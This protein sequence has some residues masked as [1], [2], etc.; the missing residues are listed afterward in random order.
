MGFWI[1]APHT[2]ERTSFQKYRGANARSVMNGKFLN[3]KNDGRWFIHRL[4]PPST[5][6]QLFAAVDTDTLPGN[7]FSA[8]TA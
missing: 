8:R 6:R 5:W 7:V 3:I 2:A 1:V 4:I